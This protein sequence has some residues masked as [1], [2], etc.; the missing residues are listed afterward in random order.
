MKV[1]SNTSPII[2]LAAIGQLDLLRRLYGRII[3]PRAV[4]TEITGAGPCEPGAAEVRQLDWIAVHEVANRSLVAALRLELDPGEAEAIACALETQANRL[5]LDERLGRAVAT[6]LGIQPIG[7][8]GVLIEA[9]RQ[10]MLPA[11]KP[12][13][14][15]LITQAGFWIAKPLYSRV[16]AAADEG[17][18]PSV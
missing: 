18:T 5:L 15:A 12:P 17:Y 4:H 14:D 1:V 2:N 9:K 11:V 7:V 8:L 6:R 10:G 13:L 16:L 3:I